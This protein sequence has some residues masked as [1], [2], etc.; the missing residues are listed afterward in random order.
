MQAGQDNIFLPCE[1]ACRRS[2][3]LPVS[4][5]MSGAWVTEPVTSAVV[6]TYQPMPPTRAWRIGEAKQPGPEAELVQSPTH[7]S[8][9]PLPSTIAQEDLDDLHHCLW[10]P[11]TP[12]EATPPGAG[13]DRQKK[14][15]FPDSLLPPEH[16][17]RR[18]PWSEDA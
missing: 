13:R 11:E 17:A 6:P 8:D 3:P 18:P 5:N 4:S 10:S 2:T 1:G 7:D 9:M 12:C 15:T 14:C 16:P